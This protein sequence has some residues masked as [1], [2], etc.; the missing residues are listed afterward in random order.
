VAKRIQHGAQDGVKLA[1]IPVRLRPPGCQGDAQL[2]L[3]SAFDTRFVIDDAM[4]ATSR[5][6]LAPHRD[7]RRRRV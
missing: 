7:K 1:L 6:V 3:A 4:W 5:V 2:V